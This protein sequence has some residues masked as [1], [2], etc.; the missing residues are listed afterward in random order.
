[1]SWMKAIEE[2]LQEIAQQQNAPQ[3]RPPAAPRPV[4]R[5]PV[6]PVRPAVEAEVIPEGPEA[7]DVATH[8]SQHITTAEIAQHTA[9]LGTEVRQADSKIQ[10][11]LQSKFDHRVASIDARSGVA[12][13]GGVSAQPSDKGARRPPVTNEL[14]QM[15][16]N[17][18]T[19]RQAILLNEIFRRPEERW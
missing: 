2:L 10:A 3:Q 7:A 6:V 14:V 18:K 13:R 19:I 4:Q 5:R 12:A 16:R 8:V 17:P 9:G 11:H 15:L 1:V